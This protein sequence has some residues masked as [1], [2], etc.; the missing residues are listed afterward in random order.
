MEP[1]RGLGRV[2][3]VYRRVL[4][5]SYVVHLYRIHAMALLVALTFHQPIW[6]GPLFDRIGKEHL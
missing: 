1:K 2:L 6:H 4:L 5:F 3:L